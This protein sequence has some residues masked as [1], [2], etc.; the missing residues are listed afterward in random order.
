MDKW[1]LSKLADHIRT[2]VGVVLLLFDVV[3]LVVRM[4]GD[5]TTIYQFLPPILGFVGQ[6]PVMV[7]LFLAGIGLIFW[8]IHEIRTRSEDVVKRHLAQHL[9]DSLKVT[10]I[11]VLIFAI[12]CGGLAVYRHSRPRVVVVGSSQVSPPIAPPP[13]MVHPG[14]TPAPEKNKKGV[15]A[16]SPKISGASPKTPPPTMQQ[17]CA[18]G[19]SCAMSTGQQGGIT[20]GTVNI[21]IKPAVKYQYKDYGYVSPKDASYP[22]QRKIV[23]LTNVSTEPTTI[24]IQ[25]SAAIDKLDFGW[26]RGGTLEMF[27]SW[28]EPDRNNIGFLTFEHPAFLP[29]I[30]LEVT[31]YSKNEFGIVRVLPAIKRPE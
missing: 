1:S 26:E 10:G 4:L 12:S 7:L 30:G 5:A 28:V 14:T 6:T 22:Y 21:G 31:I 17:D 2:P 15:T 8:E 23:I 13:Q 20:A 9:K 27:T 24:G 11:V 19:S 25:C 18:P 3:V 29:E 16:A